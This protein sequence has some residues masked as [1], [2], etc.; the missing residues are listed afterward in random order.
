MHENV[1]AFC[2]SR[3]PVEINAEENIPLLKRV[4]R[5]SQPLGPLPST[6]DGES[7]DDGE[8]GDIFIHSTVNEDFDHLFET[9][10]GPDD[11][12][13]PERFVERKENDP[14][15]RCR[16]VRDLMP[17]YPDLDVKGAEPQ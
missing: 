16:Y 5:G 17:L 3:L 9:E 12:E 6:F 2:S 13:I 15:G 8:D 10:D 1:E 11:H 4:A 14:Y 7:S